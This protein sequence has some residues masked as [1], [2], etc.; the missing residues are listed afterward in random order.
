[1]QL[2]APAFQ[3]ARLLH[4]AHHYQQHTTWHTNKPELS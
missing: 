4:A 3:E 2:L 1:M